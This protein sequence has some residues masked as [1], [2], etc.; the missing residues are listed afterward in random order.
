MGKPVFFC[1]KPGEGNMKS[2]YFSIVGPVLNSGKECEKILRRLPEWFG[3][4]QTMIDY[5]IEIDGLPTFMINMHHQVCGF[6]SLKMHYKESAELYVLG[7]LPEYH[8]QGLGRAAV[9]SVTEYCRNQGIEYLQIK[10]LG[11]A[12]NWPSYESTRRFYLSLGFRP[13]EEFQ[14]LWGPNCPCLQMIKKIL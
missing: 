6:I 10:T 5:G 3:D 7:I 9:E 12:T 11:P 8:H 13:L 1:A 2:D 4:E 14:T